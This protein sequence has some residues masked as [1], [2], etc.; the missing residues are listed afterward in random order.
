MGQMASRNFPGLSSYPNKL[1]LFLLVSFNINALSTSATPIQPPLT[2]LK[3]EYSID[4]TQCLLLQANSSSALECWNHLS[5]S[6]SAYEAF[7]VPLHDLLTGRITLIYKLQK[8]ASFFERA[9][10]L[11]GDYPTS[12][13]N[14]ANKLF[15]TYYNSLQSF[16]PQSPLIEGP[17]TKHTPLLQQASLCFSASE[18]N[19]PVGSLTPNQCN[20]TIIIKHPSDHQTNRVDYQVS[21][22]AN[23]AFLHSAR[24]TASPSTNASGLTCAVPG[25]HLFPWFNVN[26]TTSDHIKCVKNNSFYISTIVGVSLASS[27]SIWSNE[28]QER[29]N[30]PTLTHLFSFH[31]SA[32]IYDKGSIFLCGTNTYLCLPT[33]WTGTCTLVYLSLSIGL[34]PPNQ[35]LPIRLSNIL[36]KEGPS[37]SI[38]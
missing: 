33:N 26:G 35:P 37:M 21:P 5:L 11:L 12:R 1:F 32:C 29:K 27:L 34:V 10:T 9:D 24:F 25:V 4:L 6:S 3:L 2:A 20:R 17:I 30:T 14:Q 13:A 8:G 15:Q 19:F 28:P 7:P 38:P 36:G 16:K 31:I 22:E 23:G 18:G